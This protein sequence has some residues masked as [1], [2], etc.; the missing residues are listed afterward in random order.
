MPTIRSRL[1]L[2]SIHALREEGDRYW[3]FESRTGPQFLSTPSARRATGAVQ[4]R[5]MH[6]PISI[7]ALRE[8]GDLHG[9]AGFFVVADFYPRPPRG[10]R[11]TLC[12]LTPP[13][14]CISIHALR[15]EGDVLPD[16]WEVDDPYFYPRPPR[17]GRPSPLL[18][19]RCISVDFYPRPPRGGRQRLLDALELAVE[20]LSTPSARRATRPRKEPGTGGGISIHAL[21]EEGDLPCCD[22]SI[23]LFALFLSTPSARRAT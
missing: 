8:E 15:E 17:G 7:H 5:A 2:I 20:F 23:F 18:G 22:Y 1:F 21:R 9:A 4:S 10:G 11:P 6:R 16:G 13:C 3:V 19:H 12:H 14:R